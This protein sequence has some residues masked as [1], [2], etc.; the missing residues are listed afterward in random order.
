MVEG[1]TMSGVGLFFV[2][3][4][5]MSGAATYSQMEMT[6]LNEFLH[7]LGTMTTNTNFVL[8]VAE[9][10]VYN[11]SAASSPSSLAR[12][13]TTNKG[14]I[15]VFGAFNFDSTSDITV[16]L[17]FINRGTTDFWMGKTSFIGVYKN[18]QNFTIKQFASVVA[19]STSCRRH[20]FRSICILWGLG[21]LHFVIIYEHLSRKSLT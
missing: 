3:Q 18:Y 10:A 9:T 13:S 17:D 5:Y 14:Q 7:A 20:Q 11:L 19:T 15:V 6:V 12:T 4:V 8:N 21:I 16:S 1:G 2:D